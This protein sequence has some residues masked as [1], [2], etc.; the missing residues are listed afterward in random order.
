MYVYINGSYMI[1]CDPYTVCS[2]MVHIWSSRQPSWHPPRACVPV[3]LQNSGFSLIRPGAPDRWQCGGT[4]G[5]GACSVPAGSMQL[6]H[7]LDAGCEQPACSLHPVCMQLACSLH[8]ACMQPTRNL[9][10]IAIANIQLRG[11]LLTLYNT[12]RTKNSI[13]I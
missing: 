3:T 8:A 12:Q 13:K 6:S 4:H 11:M 10:A 5:R 1:I 9:Y 7:H 2:D